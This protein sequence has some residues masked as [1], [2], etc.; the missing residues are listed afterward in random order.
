MSLKKIKRTF[1]S[2]Y[3]SRTN[4]FQQESM[5]NKVDANETDGSKE[6]FKNEMKK[7]TCDTRTIHDIPSSIIELTK[8]DKEKLKYVLMCNNLL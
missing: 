1:T 6:I 3:I 7:T 2:C 4:S 5:I 8:E